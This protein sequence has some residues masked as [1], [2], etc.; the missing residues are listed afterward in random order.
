MA[1]LSADL[2]GDMKIGE[3]ASISNDILHYS[4]FFFCELVNEPPAACLDCG[5][6][7]LT[8]IG[9][10]QLHRERDIHIDEFTTRQR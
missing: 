9:K 1:L 8:F 10:R 4:A 3:P 2:S 7:L 6:G 5:Q